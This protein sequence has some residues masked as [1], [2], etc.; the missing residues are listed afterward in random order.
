MGSQSTSTPTSTITIS[1]TVT[2]F[3]E[4]HVALSIA[5][6]TLIYLG[7]ATTHRS[8]S[9]PKLVE[10]F[11]VEVMSMSDVEVDEVSGKVYVAIKTG[12][13]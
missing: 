4:A 6:T 7:K 11:L 9:L 8:S 3:T 10:N 12:K 1:G 5:L 13:P 2:N